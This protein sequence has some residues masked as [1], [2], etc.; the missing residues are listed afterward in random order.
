MPHFVNRAMTQQPKSI[1]TQVTLPPNVDYYHLRREGIAQAQALSGDLWTDYNEHDPGVTILEQLCYALTE[2][3]YKTNYDIEVFL[4]AHLK[5]AGKHAFFPAHEIF[6]AHPTSFMDWRKLIL[7]HVPAVKNA[8]ILPDNE[9][10]YNVRGLYRVQ[11]Q[12]NDVQADKASALRAEVLALLNA[13]RNVC[14]DVS[15]IEILAA[16]VLHIEATIVIGAT[17]MGEEVLAQVA[18]RLQQFVNPSIRRYSLA[19]LQA[20]GHPLHEIFDGP[21]PHQGFILDEDLRPLVTEIYTSRLTKIILGID[22]VAAVPVLKVYKDGELVEG[23]LIQMDERKF[24]ILEVPLM[25]SD[26]PAIQLLQNGQPYEIDFSTANHIFTTLDSSTQSSFAGD[27]RVTYSYRT[28]E[29]PLSA[30]AEYYSI[31]HQFPAVYGIGDLG[32]SPRAEVKRHA[33]AKQLKAYLFVFEQHMA[34]YLVQL[35]KVQDLFSL[36]EQV[37]KSYFFQVM[38]SIPRWQ[39]LVQYPEQLYNELE[40]IHKRYDNFE[41]RRAKFIDHLLAR[42]NEYIDT[43]QLM[44]I[45]KTVLPK[46]HL[47]KA[48]QEILNNKLQLLRDYVTLG[49]TRGK[50]WDYTQPLSPDN[51]AG[52]VMR[53]RLLLNIRPKGLSLADVITDSQLHVQPLE[54]TTPTAE[55]IN[56]QEREIHYETIGTSEER[57]QFFSEQDSILEEV[58]TQGIFK[59][60]YEVYEQ[61]A[62]YTVLFKFGRNKRLELYQSDNIDACKAM[63]ERTIDYL[64]QLNKDSE[65]FHLVE[66]HLLRPHAKPLYGLRLVDEDN[67]PLLEQYAFK[68]I[69]E[70]ELIAE[71]IDKIGRTVSHY[72]I[73]KINGEYWVM[74]YNPKDERTSKDTLDPIAQS[75]QAF[76][77]AQ[78]AEE[79]ALRIID[80]LTS[81]YNSG[82]DILSLVQFPSAEKRPYFV[83]NAFYS[84]QVSVVLPRWCNRFKNEGFR[85]ILT[86]ALQD[87]LPAHITLYEHWLSYEAML[88]LETCYFNWA[89]ILRTQSQDIDLLDTAA[90]VVSHLLY[91]F[92]QPDPALRQA[93]DDAKAELGW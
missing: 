67:L 69:E 53:L 88:E 43:A 23:D 44:T 51:V 78:A 59:R 84:F 19:E 66:H 20:Q 6:P 77:T 86:H 29:L 92:M 74:L 41:E 91:Y 81:S 79:A 1:P 24:P 71:N 63:I 33:Q 56:L 38:D 22:G 70:Q 18:H 82:T 10:L 26:T 15:S 8:W 40:R 50:A 9:N 83:P 62:H 80:F 2:L 89:E 42:F 68:T 72:R 76:P 64:H 57:L 52:L 25:E 39:E 21:V 17:A 27:T 7:Y 60:N 55:S 65:G 37:D 30:F 75:P 45:Y 85:R 16:N 31:Q 4:R 34:N 3:G 58:L 28:P 90:Y 35:S 32:V 47:A 36:D 14:E 48:E 73:E 87:N 61:E 5:E 46:P 93:I 54:N 13:H 12:L 49:R 11:L